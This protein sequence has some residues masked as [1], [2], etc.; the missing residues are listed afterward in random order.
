MGDLRLRAEYLPLGFQICQ[1]CHPNGLHELL[2]AFYTVHRERG[3]QG[4]SRSR[5]VWGWVD[6]L[7]VTRVTAP[8]RSIKGPIELFH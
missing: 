7:R 4:D 3:V 6:A 1:I 5:D 2:G 8:F